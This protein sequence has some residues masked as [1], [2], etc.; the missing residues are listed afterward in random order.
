MSVAAATTTRGADFL[1][2]CVSGTSGNPELEHIREKG[3]EAVLAMHRAVK[4]ATFHAFENDAVK[5]TVE[6][7]HAVLNEFAATIG[8]VFSV[9]FVDDTIF[10]SGQ[11]LRA[12][13][14]IYEA[15]AELGE[16]L[17][18]CNV[19]EV[20]VTAEVTKEDVGAF[21]LAT[22]KA[23]RD[24]ALA[25]TL[26]DQKIPGITF[27]KIE[28]ALARR[29]REG[30]L[31]L[32]SRFL[33]LYASALVV[34][35]RFFDGIAAGSPVVV[36]R[37]KRIAQAFVSLVEKGDAGLLALTTLANAHRD[38]AGRALQ[39]AIL[40]LAL[41][42]QLTEDRVTLARLVMSAM[43]TDVGRVKVAGTEGR[44]RFVPLGD[45]VE[46]SVPSVASAISIVT[47]G[48]NPQAAE[49]TVVVFEANWVERQQ[50]LG[51]VHGGKLPPLLVARM[52]R[53]VRVVHER[54]AP[55]D[56]SRPLPI[57]DALREAARVPG[58]DATLL[59][60]LVH[61]LGLTPAGSVVE[62]ETGEWGVVVGPSANPDAIDRPRVRLVVDRKGQVLDPPQEVDLGAPLQ[63]VRLPKITRI[64]GP[65]EARFNVTRA[66][67]CA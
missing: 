52:L 21:A 27:R 19:S 50:L 2:R 35:R 7:S 41:G 58:V 39:T 17:N 31:P 36:H 43:L 37:V 22:V 45:E 49:R 63:Q 32:E 14:A 29:E 8:G 40:A 20:S 53:V 59:K 54:L 4:I 47:G 25:A 62:L 42:R 44:D 3:A 67:V 61:A 11:L 65:A 13:R 9:T 15:A 26:V 28:L 60:L 48:V 30:D 18:R 33:R 16:L 64:V 66:L 38:D 10:V 1:A 56:A 12:T 34:L 24:P 57:L 55:R 5:R 23:L 6:Q 46:S 51:P